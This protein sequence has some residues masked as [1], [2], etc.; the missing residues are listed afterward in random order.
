MTPIDSLRFLATRL[1]EPVEDERPGSSD[2]TDARR[3]DS[4]QETRRLE[5][6]L[7]ER[8]S[9]C[10]SVLCCSACHV[11]VAKEKMHE[12]T[13]THLPPTTRQHVNDHIIPFS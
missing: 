9:S 2:V 11:C 1:T 5:T 13:N 7:M 8:E 3:N 10:L 12:F 6:R 4:N